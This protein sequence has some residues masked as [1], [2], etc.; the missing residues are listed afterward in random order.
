VE[1]AEVLAIACGHLREAECS[2]ALAKQQLQRWSA[3]IKTPSA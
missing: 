2:E 1:K 3:W